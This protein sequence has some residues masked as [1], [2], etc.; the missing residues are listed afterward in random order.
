VPTGRLITSM[1]ADMRGNTDE[2]WSRAMNYL[3]RE[4]L[5]APHYGAPQSR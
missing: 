5:L 3:V 4:R 2:S 1:S